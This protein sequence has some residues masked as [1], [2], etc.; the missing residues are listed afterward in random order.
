[1]RTRRNLPRPIQ[2]NYYRTRRNPSLADR[3]QQAM[4]EANAANEQRYQDILKGYEDLHGR[5]LGDLSGVGDQEKRDIDRRYDNMG[6]DVYQ[7]LVNR[8]FGNSTIPATMQAGVERERSASQSRLASDLARMRA[9]ADQNITG[10]RLGVM[11]RRTD[12]QPDINQ[13]IALSQGLGR[14]GYGSGG[15][16]G[17]MGGGGF[18][19]S[20]QAYRNAYMQSMGRMMMGMGMGGATR[21]TYRDKN[22][23]MKRA[24]WAMK[25]AARQRAAPVDHM[26][27]RVNAMMSG[28]F[29]Q[30]APP[31]PGF[32]GSGGPWSPQMT[33]Q[34][35]YSYHMPRQVRNYPWAG[36]FQ[37]MGVQ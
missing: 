18:G 14:G 8:G 28:P 37:M 19:I 12:A 33:Q 5:V 20:P 2:G 35:G 26:Q 16:G 17:G 31:L 30:A 6:S 22:R 7:R 11:E 13:M 10:Q 3:Y 32:L 15:F 36:G 25:R 23:D 29:P 9:N 1:M 21:H 27:N 24:M 34:Q 4:N